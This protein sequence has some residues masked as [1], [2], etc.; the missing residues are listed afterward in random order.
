MK[1]QLLFPIFIFC[2]LMSFSAYPQYK[3]DEQRFYS[4]ENSEWEQ[5]LTQKSK[6]DNEGDKE[7][8]LLSIVMPSSE[9]QF[10]QTKAYNANNLIIEMV[11]E[12]W[13]PTLMDWQSMAKTNY[14][15]ESSQIKSETTQSYNP[16]TTA[17]INS[18]RILYA[19]SDSNLT[20]ETKQNWN[21]GA[22]TW[23]D[24]SRKLY[25]Y[26]GINLIK[27]TEQEWN[28]GAK[29]WINDE[30]TEIAYDSSGKMIQTIIREWDSDLNKWEF[31]ERITYTYTVDMITEA[32][33]EEY[34]N[35]A[36]KLDAR[37]LITYNNGLATEV[38]YQERR[39]SEWINE[40]RSLTTFDTNGNATIIIIEE[41]D[42]TD[43]VWE[44][45]SK[46][47]RDYSLVKPFTL[48]VP[49]F[50]MENF[51]VFPNPATDIINVS[52]VL[53]VDKME[54]YDVLGKKVKSS[55]IDNLI[56]T[57]DLKSGLYVLKVYQNDMST[58]QR[59]L[60]K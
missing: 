34:E 22:N 16:N 32:I 45:E 14:T 47:E 44:P 37:T 13:I 23:T 6:F 25:E 18:T 28:A 17:Y 50:N 8:E 54:L 12:I 53:K 4:W 39:G 40:D 10:R 11:S 49:T 30:V 15:Y 36:W 5:E 52:S 58:T 42:E 1:Q 29:A 46:I 20:N 38:L 24:S 59:I 26:S 27:E 2:I 33:N 51:K 60:V 55:V 9:N 57:D 31:D 43:K 56:R 35:G 19:Y 7:T 48:S 3:V 41:W 21:S